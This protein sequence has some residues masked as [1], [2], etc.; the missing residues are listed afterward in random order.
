MNRRV[1]W[2]IIIFITAALLGISLIQMY[3]LRFSIDLNERRFDQSVFAAINNVSEMLDKVEEEESINVW[4][5]EDFR[6]GSQERSYYQNK[7]RSYS[8]RNNERRI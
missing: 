7:I 6:F 5:R 1:T 2:I 8:R 3:W 4:E